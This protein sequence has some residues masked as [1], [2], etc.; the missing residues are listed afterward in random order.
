M[1]KLSSLRKKNNL[2]FVRDCTCNDLVKLNIIILL[3][4]IHTIAFIHCIFLQCLTLRKCGF[5]CSRQ[6]ET[7]L[8]RNFNFYRGLRK[9][10]LHFRVIITTVIAVIIR[11]V[12]YKR[13]IIFTLLYF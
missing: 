1:R 11:E 10:G 8:S 6:F 12:S 4:V 7:F 3:A 13:E 9:V 2:L 5:W